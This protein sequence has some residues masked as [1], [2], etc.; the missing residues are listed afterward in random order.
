MK[1]Q[2]RAWIM[3]LV[4]LL[5]WQT[6]PASPFAYFAEMLGQWFGLASRQFFSAAAWQAVFVYLLFILLLA[7]LLL[8]GRSKNRVYLAGVCSLATLLQH[9]VHC[10]KTG[11]IYA[12]SPAIAI[13]LALSLLFLLIRA[14]SPALW[15]TDAYLMAL[16]AWLVR[17]AVLPPLLEL[18]GLNNSALARYLQL[19]EKPLAG[20]LLPAGGLA[21]LVFS[22]VLLLL[23]LLPLIFLA[24]GRQ[25][26]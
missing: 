17:D 24:R 8:A 1:S 7:G 9:L 2:N 12:V 21:A 13:G 11:S 10:I 20:N 18:A 22:L 25:K 3:L 19:P 26:G 14:K 15:L 16:P 5:A 4:I 23:A 6:L